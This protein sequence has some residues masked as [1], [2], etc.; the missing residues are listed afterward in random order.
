MPA[1]AG[2][3]TDWTNPWNARHQPLYLA[4]SACFRRSRGALSCITCH[5]PHQQVSRDPS[6]YDQ[7]CKVCHASPKHRTTVSWACSACHMPAVSPGPHLRFANHWI[8]V[9]AKDRPLRPLVR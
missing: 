6:F 3:E 4:E 5:P 9:Y 7:R 2:D 8:G 1:S